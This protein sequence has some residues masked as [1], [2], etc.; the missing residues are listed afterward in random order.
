M[1]I[2][3]YVKFK[4]LVEKTKLFIGLYLLESV[5]IFVEFVAIFAYPVNGLTNYIITFHKLGC[6]SVGIFVLNP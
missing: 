2:K 1:V 3:L 5:C 6:F 4:Y